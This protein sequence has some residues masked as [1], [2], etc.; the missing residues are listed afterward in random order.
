MTKYVSYSSSDE[1]LVSTLEDEPRLL[2]LYFTEGGR[3][4]DDYD[5]AEHNEPVEV[6]AGLKAG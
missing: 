2:K 4:R 5:R 3:S 6:T 1:V